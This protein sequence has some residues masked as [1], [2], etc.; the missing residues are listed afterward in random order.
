MVRRPASCRRLNSIEAHLGQIERLDKHVDQTS[1]RTA[2][3]RQK[4]SSPKI[5]LLTRAA[6]GDRKGQALFRPDRVEMPPPV[7]SPTRS[8]WTRA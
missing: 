7:Q 2:A 8:R 3:L 4:R 6:A 1:L 5:L